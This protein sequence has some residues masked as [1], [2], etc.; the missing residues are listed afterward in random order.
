MDLSR[1]KVTMERIRAGNPIYS[2][3]IKINTFILIKSQSRKSWAM[4]SKS[5]LHNNRTN[6]RQVSGIPKISKLRF[7]WAVKKN[8]TVM[9]SLTMRR[10]VIHK[11]NRRLNRKNNRN[12]RQ[13]K[14]KKKR[15][16]RPSSHRVKLQKMIK[17]KKEVRQLCKSLNQIHKRFVK[18]KMW[19]D[20]L[21]VVGLQL[22]L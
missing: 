12:L 16:N 22:L 3:T 17:R 2:I 14:I 21:K 19:K 13:I 6:Q 5:Q 20:P 9:T 1:Y 11:I 10:K 4:S 8:I 7:H 15:M 18:M